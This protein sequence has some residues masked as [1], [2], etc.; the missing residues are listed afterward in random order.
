MHACMVM[1]GPAFCRMLRDVERGLSTD[2][3]LPRLG[4][5]VLIDSHEEL[6]NFKSSC[7][8]AF[9]LSSKSICRTIGVIVRKT[10]QISRALP[11]WEID[12]HRRPQV[13]LVR[14]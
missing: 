2:S 5:V 4:R 13:P 11:V 1:G 7:L 14:L 8:I 9:L 6:E 10:N 12:Q 3:M